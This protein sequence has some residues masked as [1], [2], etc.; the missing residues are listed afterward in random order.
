MF[1]DVSLYSRE[2]KWILFVINL[3]F[4]SFVPNFIYVQYQENS[5]IVVR[6]DFYKLLRK[7]NFIFPY[8]YYQWG[9]HYPFAFLH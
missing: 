8:A 3:K 1:H 2:K 4:L 6:G 5:I 7:R 9:N